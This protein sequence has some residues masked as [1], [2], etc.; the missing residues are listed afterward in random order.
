MWDQGS[1]GRLG[2]EG[3]DL[4]SQVQDQGSL[5]MELGS[6]VFLGIRDQTITTT[7]TTTDYAIFVGSGTKICHAFEISDQKS[8][9]KNV[10]R[11]EKH[12]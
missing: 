12:S 8:D 5:A 3:W 10:F 6:A 4:G 2:S 11:D 9:Y 7:T 1:E